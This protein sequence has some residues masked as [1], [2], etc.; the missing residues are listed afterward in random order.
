L[1]LDSS[2]PQPLDLTSSAIVAVNRVGGNLNQVVK[3]ANT[4][5]VLPPDLLRELHAVRAEIDALRQAFLASL[6]GEPPE[7]SEALP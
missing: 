2:S 5:I 6:R 4:G 1:G 7:A 3:L